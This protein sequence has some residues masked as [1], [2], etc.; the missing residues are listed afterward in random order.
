MMTVHE[1]SRMTGVSIRALQ[2]YDRIGLLRPASYSEAG[3]RLYDDGSLEVLQQILLFRELEFPLKEIKQ[4]IQAPSFDRDKALEQQIELLRLKKEHLEQLID[5]ACE[6]RMKGGT[7]MDFSAFDTAK[8][9]E[10]AAQVKARW[11]TTDAYYEYEEKSKNRTVE[12]ENNLSEQLMQIFVELG[13][14]KDNGPAS[15]EAQTLIRQLQ[16]F[17]SEH[18]YACSKEILSGLGQMYASGG[19]MTK[20]IDRYGGEGTGSF[21]REAIQ[22]YCT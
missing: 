20:N 12:E 22:I 21:A 15:E 4:I 2:Y 18:Y 8:M 7:N 3:Y 13:K 11:G 5:L 16:E 14:V 17:I 19:D 10:Y 1:V 6:I 9:E